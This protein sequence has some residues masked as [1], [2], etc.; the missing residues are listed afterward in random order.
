MFLKSENNVYNTPAHPCTTE[1]TCQTTQQACMRWFGNSYHVYVSYQNTSWAFSVQLDAQVSEDLSPSALK[2]KN[3]PSVH[4]ERNNQVLLQL[5]TILR[6]FWGYRS[7]AFENANLEDQMPNAL[8]IFKSLKEFVPYLRPQ[9]HLI[10]D[11]TYHRYSG[12]VEPTLRNMSVGVENYTVLSHL[13]PYSAGK[14]TLIH[15]LTG[16][17]E[18]TQGSALI[19]G[20]NTRTERMGVCPQHDVFWGDLAITHKLL[21]Y[22]RLCGVPLPWS[23]SNRVIILDEPLTGL[24]PKVRRVI[25]GVANRVKVNCSIVLT[26]L[27]MKEADILSDRITDMGNDLLIS[28]HYFQGWTMKKFI[29]VLRTA[30]TKYWLSYRCIDKFSSFGIFDLNF[31]RGT[32]STITTAAEPVE[33]CGIRQ[34]TLEDVIFKIVTEA[35]VSLTV[36]DVVQDIKEL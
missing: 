30:N 4:S 19:A 16:L 7:A 18:P 24:D 17:Y 26:A 15:L 21:F 5:T 29:R 3:M 8:S 12:K 32:K 25:W 28:Q 23:S 9:P 10:I 14:S 11:N 6:E 33:D 36:P 1:D 22:S 13:G 2:E 31:L 35:D 27:L 20:A 34:K